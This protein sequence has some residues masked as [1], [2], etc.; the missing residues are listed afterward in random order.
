MA[1]LLLD[2][3]SGEKERYEAILAP[4]KP[5]FRVT[6]DEQDELAIAAFVDQGSGWRTF[7][8]KAAE[9]EWAGGETQFLAA[10]FPAQPDA[11]DGFH[12]THPLACPKGPDVHAV[13]NLARLF[14]VESTLRAV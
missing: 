9:N 5:V 12:L 2:R 14:E 7:D 3:Q 11:L 6:R 4:R 1:R 10:S 13:E 8:R